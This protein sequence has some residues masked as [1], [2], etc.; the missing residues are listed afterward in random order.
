MTMTPEA[1]SQ[2]S[3]T[4]R[5]LRERLLE[6]LHTAVEGA[7]RMKLSRT[8]ADLSEVPRTKRQR[9]EA[10][11]DRSDGGAWSGARHYR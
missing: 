2:L 8:Q 3:T 6:D 5:A 1:K 9:L 4:I 10:W 11:I 7:Y